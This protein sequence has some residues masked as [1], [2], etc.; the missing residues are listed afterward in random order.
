MYD[1]Q[2]LCF[3][4]R[5]TAPLAAAAQSA[6]AD[7]AERQALDA[8]FKH[9]KFVHFASLALLPGHTD[10]PTPSLMLELAVDD[11]LAPGVVLERL[12][13]AGLGALRPLAFGPTPLVANDK[14]AR[15]QLLQR[16][17][18]ALA[19][20]PATGGF[21][22]MRDRTAAQIREE[23]LYFLQTRDLMRQLRSAQS[24]GTPVPT[25]AQWVSR[26]HDAMAGNP[27]RPALG[28]PPPTTFWCR[29]RPAP[30]QLLFALLWVGLPVPALVMVLAGVGA[31]AAMLVQAQPAL[32]GQVPG[33]SGAAVAGL[34]LLAATGGVLFLLF[35]A[36]FAIGTLALAASVLGVAWLH[37]V[38]LQHAFGLLQALWP[39]PAPP[40]PAAA[41][42]AGACVLALVLAFLVAGSLSPAWRRRWARLGTWAGALV[43]ALGLLLLVLDT[44]AVSRAEPL[45]AML[46]LVPALALAALLLRRR[47]LR[48]WAALLWGVLP[49]VLGLLL[50][51]A[52]AGFSETRL[53]VTPAA[54]LAHTVFG[55]LSLLAL[56]AFA[57]VV[58]ALRALAALRRPLWP[59]A[60]L[61]LG[62]VL[63]ASV[64]ALLAGAL[65]QALYRAL[66]LGSLPAPAEAAGWPAYAVP[67]LAACGVAVLLLFA[68]RG[69]ADRALPALAR[70]ERQLDRPPNPPDDHV[71]HDVH[72]DIL[73]GEARLF[74]RPNHMINLCDVRGRPGGMP[75]LMLR[76][77]LN[78]VGDA[79][80]AWFTRGR[81][82]SAWGI[83]FGHWHLIDG[84]RRL[85]FV[86]NFDFDFGGYLDEFIRGTP[87]GI[88][89]I[90][91]WTEL[92]ARPAAV[93][94]QPAVDRPRSFPPTYRWGFRGCQQELHFKAYARAG[95]VPHL[96]LYQAYTQAS[97]EIR[98]ATRLR[99]LLA[100]PRTAAS[101][102]EVMRILSS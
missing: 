57:F 14:D 78:I 87:L 92:R 48:W 15:A 1:R 83:K 38:L 101:D 80:H 46:V 66:A 45:T 67:Y 69:V 6:L 3:V 50:V 65:G 64:A 34:A 97:T 60:P 54:L 47:V 77:W 63:L 85:L 84:G 39:L 4:L 8:L 94:G 53:W 44:P 71:P 98:A 23:A 95:M 35:R 91:R 86:S 70:L 42:L 27:A 90:W 31:L 81:L 19:D 41:G 73:A 102:D 13:E 43:L 61:L 58:V 62:G 7:A 49:L 22:G 100:G 88:N 74:A 20:A 12:V 56:L 52:A 76:L 93:P 32:F 29:K 16:L 55:G 28:A 9:L 59:L 75:S 25:A 96:Y 40:P 5:T 30:L 37:A 33:W 72:E 82:G 11:G 68:L 10:D 24:P 21:I 17:R 51:M 26:L 79:G 18:G 36:H 89:M 99:Q 2:M